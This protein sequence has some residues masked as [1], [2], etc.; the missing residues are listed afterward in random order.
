M[1]GIGIMPH[2]HLLV[3]CCPIDPKERNVPSQCIINL[4]MALTGLNH[5]TVFGPM[6]QDQVCLDL[7]KLT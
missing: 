2:A 3:E 6:G 5:L 4:D 7:P 1:A